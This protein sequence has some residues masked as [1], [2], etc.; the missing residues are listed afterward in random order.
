MVLGVEA[1]RDAEGVVAVS[2]AATASIGALGAFL[3][4]RGRPSRRLAVGCRVA[5]RRDQ[6][7][8]PLGAVVLP[9]GVGCVARPPL[10]GRRG[11]SSHRARPDRELLRRAVAGSMGRSSAV[12]PV[13]RS[14]GRLDRGVGHRRRWHRAAGGHGGFADHDSPTA[15]GLRPGQRR[16]D[17]GSR[18]SY[19]AGHARRLHP[20]G[21]PSRDDLHLRG[22]SSCWGWRSGAAAPATPSGRCPRCR[23]RRDRPGDPVPPRGQPAVPHLLHKRRSHRPF[24]PVAHHTQRQ[25]AHCLSPQDAVTASEFCSP[26]KP[27]GFLSGSAGNSNRTAR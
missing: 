15:Q 9:R 12:S 21:Q 24:L 3:I 26:A 17:P 1:A 25:K 18:S 4:G 7:P 11:R 27:Q 22:R 10:S 6:Q 2:R 13:H 19:L 5:H 14:G 23:G 8:V 20:D 16:T